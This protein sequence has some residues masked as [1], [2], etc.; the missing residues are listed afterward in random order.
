V[1]S[2]ERA[3]T[4]A[5]RIASFQA[6]PP[7]LRFAAVVAGFGQL[8]RRD[9][10]VVDLTFADVRR[11]ASDAVGADPYGYRREFVELVETAG[12]LASKRALR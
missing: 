3:I 5:D 8:L 10:R 11:M 12:E 6:A 4:D 1:Q 7:D 9:T 2:L